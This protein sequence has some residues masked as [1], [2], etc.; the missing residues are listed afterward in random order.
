MV[1][2]TTDT[3]RWPATVAHAT[4]AGTA[5]WQHASL[6]TGLVGLASVAIRGGRDHLGACLVLSVLQAALLSAGLW[7]GLR[8]RIDAAL[9]RALAGA[10]GT[11][12]FDRAM[13]QLGLLSADKVGRPM[14]DRVAGLMRLVR[15]L[16]LVVSAQLAL[17]VAAG[18]LAWR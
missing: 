2:E 12:E 17:L 18:W 7:L 13:T 15:L 11:D 3:A 5:A 9:F 6:A 10:D 1:A 8:L 16:A 14:P 4:A